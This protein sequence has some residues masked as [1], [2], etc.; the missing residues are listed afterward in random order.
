[1]EK[2]KADIVRD[3]AERE[4]IEPARKR[5]ETQVRIV[6]GDVQ[7]ALRLENRIALVCSALGGKKFLDQNGL[8][9]ESRE[10][11]PSGMS[12]TVVFTYSLANVPRTNGPSQPSFL[13]LRGIAKQVFQALGGG[14]SFIRAERDRFNGDRPK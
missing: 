9:L 13:R 7:R 11:P 8:S 2:K 1:M 10:G 5:G 6:A 3:F 12:T 4:Y 14:E